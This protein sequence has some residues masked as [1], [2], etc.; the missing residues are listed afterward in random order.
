ME[1]QDFDFIQARIGYDFSNTD[2]LQFPSA[3]V[4]PSS[5]RTLMSTRLSKADRR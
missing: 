4:F 5:S 2:L 3:Q 1:K